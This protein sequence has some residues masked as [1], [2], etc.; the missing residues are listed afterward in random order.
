MF[1]ALVVMAV[2]TS[3]MSGPAMYRIL[4]LRKQRRVSD[5]I[6]PRGFI[7]P[8]IADNREQAIRAL[9]VPA[10][11]ASG[12]DRERIVRAVLQ[13]EELMSTGIGTGIAIPHARMEGLSGAVVTLGISRHGIDFNA[14]DGDPAHLIFLI[15]TPLEDNTAQIEILSLVSRLF[16]DPQVRSAAMQAENYTE[17]LALLRSHQS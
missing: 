2:A 8:I 7:N 4:G 12:L 9:A 13:R 10:A 6:S 17:F 3:M 15:L 11:Q 5:F 1:V 16:R 14:P